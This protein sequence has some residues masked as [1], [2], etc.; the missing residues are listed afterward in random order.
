MAVTNLSPKEIYW[1]ARSDSP[2]GKKCGQL[3]LGEDMKQDGFR[4]LI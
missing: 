3:L 1:K 4:D 2:R